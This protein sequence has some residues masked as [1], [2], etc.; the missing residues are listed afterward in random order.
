M[1][2]NP[3]LKSSL[4]MSVATKRP[5]RHRP[6]AMPFSADEFEKLIASARLRRGREGGSPARTWW[7]AFLLT[8]LDTE[9]PKRQLLSV[10]D[11]AF[12]PSSGTLRCGG[13]EYGLRTS[14][15]AAIQAHRSTASQPRKLLFPSTNKKLLWFTFGRILA[16]ALIPD[17]KPRFRRLYATASMCPEIIERI[18]P[19]A[20]RADLPRLYSRLAHSR[21]RR[22]WRPIR[23]ANNSC[24][25]L[26]ANR[27]LWRGSS[28]YFRDAVSHFSNFCGADA[29]LDQLSDDRID[30][31]GHWCG[32]TRSKSTAA[33]LC[34]ALRTIW[35]NAK[36]AGL[37]STAPRHRDVPAVVARTPWA[38]KPPNPGGNQPAGPPTVLLENYCRPDRALAVFVESVYW[39]R[40]SP[41]CTP[42]TKYT[43]TRAV[44]LLCLYRGCVVTLDQLSEDLCEGFA[45][46]LS[47]KGTSVA[48]INGRLTALCTLWRYAFK[49]RMLDDLPRDVEL[50]PEPERLPEAW[51]IEQVAKILDAASTSTAGWTVCAAP[52]PHFWCALLLTLYDTG[53]RVG[54]VMRLKLDALDAKECW[55][56]VPARVQKHKKEQALRLDPKT[57]ELLRTLPRFPG[58]DRLL[59]IPWNGNARLAQLERWYR[60][61]LKAAGLSSGTRDLFH[62]IRRTNATYTADAQGEEMAQKRLGHSSLQLTRKNYIDPRLLRRDRNAAEL[63]PRPPAQAALSIAAETK[64]KQDGTAAPSM[65]HRAARGAHERGFSNPK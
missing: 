7:P 12:S 19:V 51:T 39:P 9:I 21:C 30:C 20:E 13:F 61:I 23:I 54:A 29:T 57:A 37:A 18:N 60:E 48:T 1:P 38:Q 31:F 36:E 17:H 43:Y 22:R 24:R 58:D 65:V 15:I 42:V 4:A 35:R 32:K 33:R 50:Y 53:L 8:V 3:E 46:W 27:S 11:T 28:R 47:K 56:T 49:K 5:R 41:F 44:G 26:K 62:K 55:L 64:F 2:A 52:A 59:P 14:T 10:P 34:S 16:T 25:A 45:A 40:R 6:D 63:I